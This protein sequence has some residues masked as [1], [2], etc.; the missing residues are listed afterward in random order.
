VKRPHLK[1]SLTT[2][3][4]NVALNRVN[5]YILPSGREWA[6][7]SWSS[8]GE[9][10]KLAPEWDWDLFTTNWFAHPYAGSM[11]YNSARSLGLSY[12]ESAAYTVVGTAMWEYL[13]EVLPPSLND[14]FTNIIG[15]FQ[16]GEVMHRISENLLDDRLYGKK[17]FSKE[18]LNF[19]INPIGEGNRLLFGLSNNH[20]QYANHLHKPMSVRFSS[21][22]IFMIN[23]SMSKDNKVI[24][25]LEFDIHYGDLKTYR[26]SFKPFDIFWFTGWF[27]FDKRD[28]S[29]GKGFPQPYWNMRSTAI[30]TGK[31]LLNFEHGYH[32][33]GIFQDYDYIKTNEYELGSLGFSG[34]WLANG[35]HEK[36]SSAFR[37]NLG[38][39]VLGA[40]NSEAIEWEKPEDPDAF[41]D[42]S[43]GSGIY[44]KIQ[45]TLDFHKLGA[46]RFRHEWWNMWVISGPS[47]LE[48]LHTINSQ[49]RIPLN[50]K[51]GLA[52][53]FNWY[54][55]NGDYSTA[56]T[57]YQE[58]EHSSEL[59]MMVTYDL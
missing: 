50:R 28:N 56:T 30:L 52:V 6:N 42:Y 54:K 21:A 10:L 47:G 24:P 31:S 19:F 43:M 23:S 18:A 16:L 8:W 36:W 34:G 1:S 41:R 57:L 51:F 4:V 46:L 7:V 9:N 14:F 33:T 48:S 58:K 25:H 15:G 40:S 12:W 22:G 32:V 49:Y 17:R 37:G 55:R 44:T 59:R 53:E 39:I 2:T 45:A 29:E 38:A 5:R 13:G 20:S 27:R 3:G 26:K 35:Y 11:Y